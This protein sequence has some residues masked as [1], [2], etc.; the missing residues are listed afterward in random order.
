M[1]FNRFCENLKVYFIVNKV[2]LFFKIWS[3]TFLE[4]D[5]VLQVK[6]VLRQEKCRTKSPLHSNLVINIVWFTC[7]YVGGDPV[8]Y[9]QL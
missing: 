4:K 5:T 8:R 3:G 6:P 7:S 2:H 1:Y 9:N